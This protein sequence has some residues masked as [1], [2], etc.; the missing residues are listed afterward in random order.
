MSHPNV[1]QA[2]VVGIPDERYGEIV[3]AFVIPPPGKSITEDELREFCRQNI[4]FYKTPAH[5]F[6][7]K[8]FPQ[9]ASGKIQ[10]FK[11]R[12]QARKI[13]NIP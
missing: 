6:V 1:D 5:F 7:V 11:L 10:K 9:T 8:E 3:G 13:L 12:E 4:A 2:E